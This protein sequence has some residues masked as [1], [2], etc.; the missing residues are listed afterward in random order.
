MDGGRPKLA[1]AAEIRDDGSGFMLYPSPQR[2]IDPQLLQLVPQRAEGDAEF[3]RGRGLVVAGF[4]QHLD[5]GLALDAGDVVVETDAASA[6]CAR[7]GFVIAA[8]VLVEVVL[9]HV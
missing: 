6:S 9:V 1:A 5:D 4:L 3:L 7:A 2:S 8:F